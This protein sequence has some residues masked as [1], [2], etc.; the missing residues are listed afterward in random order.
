MDDDDLDLIETGVLFDA[1]N[2]RFDRGV[3]L[4]A[5]D[6]VSDG[7]E[8]FR[9]YYGGGRCTAIGMAQRVAHELTVEQP[10][11]RKHDDE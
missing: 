7:E 10:M 5:L 9:F 6:D 4:A 8:G 2:R 1:L 11:Q 3:L